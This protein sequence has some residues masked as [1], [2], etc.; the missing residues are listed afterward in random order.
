VVGVSASVLQAERLVPRPLREGDLDDLAALYGDPEVVRFL[1]DGRAKTRGQA[2]EVLRRALGHWRR[3]GFGIWALLA[4]PGG[5]FV[6]RAGVAYPHGRGDAEL[7]Y[8]LARRCWGRGLATEAVRAVLRHALAVLR[9]PRV[10][11]VAQVGNVASQRVLRKAGM[12]LRGP[13]QDDG[14]E[15]L[16]Y[17]IENPA[18][19]PPRSQDE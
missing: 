5:R 12:T 6:G 9:L 18:G 7:S 15:A 4:K 14:R 1:G 19:G 16:L 17:A 2:G 11:G 8:T 10:L 3:H 13:C